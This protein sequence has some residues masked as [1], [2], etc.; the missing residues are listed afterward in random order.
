MSFTAFD[1]LRAWSARW[2]APAVRDR[3]RL[4]DEAWARAGL[5]APADHGPSWRVS[6]LDGDRATIW[7]DDV[8][9]GWNLDAKGF[10]ETLDAV[11]APD[12]DLMVNSPGG[13][14]WDGY[15]IHNALAAHPATVTAHIVGLAASAAS[16]IVMAADEIVAYRPSQVM[17]HDPAAWID[18]WGRFNPAEIQQLRRDLD[19]VEEPLEQIGDTIAGVYAGRAGGTAVEW[20]ELMRATTWY[21]PDTALAAKLVDRISEKPPAVKLAPPAEPAPQTPEDADVEDVRHQ[22]VRAGARLLPPKR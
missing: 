22:L 8:I 21:T 12:I 6:N 5:P 13:D 14:V 3:A 17:I 19:Q 18:I 2:G 9:G 1:A 11:T 20:R 7:I 4:R 15:A 16:F 10:R